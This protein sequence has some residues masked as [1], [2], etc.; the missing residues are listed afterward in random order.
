MS[1]LE[2]EWGM[3]SDCVNLSELVLIRVVVVVV[4]VL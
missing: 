2:T 3:S 4:V 1:S